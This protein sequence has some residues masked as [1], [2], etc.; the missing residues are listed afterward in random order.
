MRDPKPAQGRPWGAV[1][2]EHTGTPVYIKGVTPKRRCEVGQ[3]LFEDRES[4][5]PV[6]RRQCWRRAI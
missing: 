6:R 4:D 3:V 5:N 1:I 2:D